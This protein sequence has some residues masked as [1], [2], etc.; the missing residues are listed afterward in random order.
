MILPQHAKIDRMYK[1]AVLIVSSKKPL[2]RKHLTSHQNR[3]LFFTLHLFPLPPP[4][5]FPTILSSTYRST[6][7]SA[8]CE[9]KDV[10]VAY[11]LKYGCLA[12]PGMLLRT[13]EMCSIS[14][15][16]LS[17]PM[18]FKRSCSNRQFCEITSVSTTQA[19]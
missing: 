18:P 19:G 3:R 4:L 11:H 16:D 8:A 6:Y 9:S 17:S 1:L 5:S 15:M 7:Q 13:P 14:G 12:I 2:S 10:T